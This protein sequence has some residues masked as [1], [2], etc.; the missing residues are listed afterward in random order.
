VYRYGRNDRP[1]CEVLIDDHHGVLVVDLN[2]T[3][4]EWRFVEA[5]DEPRSTVAPGSVP[6]GRRWLRTGGTVRL[7]L[8]RQ[9]VC[10]HNG[11]RSAEEGAGWQPAMRLKVQLG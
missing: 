7:A 11:S 8:D 10:P 4:Y 1:G 3:G 6:D 2:D 5:L 9:P